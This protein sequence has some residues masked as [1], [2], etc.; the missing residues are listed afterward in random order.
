[1]RQQRDNTYR[2][3]QASSADLPG[4]ARPSRRGEMARRGRCQ[5]ERL[6]R[7]AG[8]VHLLVLAAAQKLVDDA[9]DRAVVPR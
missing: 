1:M 4:T 6:V 3:A 5:T 9:R 2:R 8:R 7:R